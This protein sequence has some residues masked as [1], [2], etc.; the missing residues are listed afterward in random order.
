MNDLRWKA[1]ALGGVL[2]AILVAAPVHGRP[3]A[4]AD[5]FQDWLSQCHAARVCNGVYL[6]AR[7]GQ[8]VFTGAVGD[9]G[10]AARTALTVESAFDIGSISKQMTAVAVLKLA[11][12]GRLAVDDRVILHLPDFPYPEVTI[13]QLLSHSS[14][15]PDVLGDYA[16]RLRPGPDERPAL[17]TID[18]T[19]IV[20]FLAAL[21]KPADAA[22][23]EAYAY[24]NTGYMVLASLV[25]TVSGQPFGE[26]LQTALFQP[27]GMTHTVL[28]TPGTE[29]AIRNR[30]AA[31]DPRP[32]D[33]RRPYDQIPGL[34]IRGAG[35]LYSTVGDLLT[36]QNALDR[37]FLSAEL[38]RRAITPV[39]LADGSTAP[40]GFGF[41]LKPDVQGEPRI[42]HAGHWRGF[43]ADL[44]SYAASRIV[45]IQLTNN[46]ED[47]SVDANTAVLRR[48]AEDQAVDR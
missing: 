41:N 35:G 48:L 7:D 25:E 6:V 40:Y 11:E 21:A 29:R 42:S 34:Y 12:H 17:A 36:W 23:G 22:P 13:A 32:D 5:A 26:Y 1:P 14:G 18:G 39:R 2:A 43:K 28:R 16:A 4:A 47:E 45:V 24:N 27:L 3:A 31:F 44:S 15:I 37:Q 46:G 8:P 30:V 10:D 19:D 20:P 38:W 33:E 9:A